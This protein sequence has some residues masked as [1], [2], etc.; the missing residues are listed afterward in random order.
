MCALLG[1]TAGSAGIQAAILEAGGW[2]ALV[3]RTSDSSVGRFAARAVLNL[4]DGTRRDFHVFLAFRLGPGR[5][6]LLE[7]Q[8]KRSDPAEGAAL[9]RSLQAV[10]ARRPEDSGYEGAHGAAREGMAQLNTGAAAQR[11]APAAPAHAVPTAGEIQ[12]RDIAEQEKLGEGS[13]GEVGWGICA[14]FIWSQP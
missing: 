6:Q 4:L 9:Q 7:E 14:V 12:W 8:L 11:A 3:P 5:V 10:S 1:L 13:F 2:E